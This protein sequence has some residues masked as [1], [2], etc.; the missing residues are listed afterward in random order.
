MKTSLRIIKYLAAILFIAQLT[1]CA[2][3]PN[4][5]LEGY[6]RQVF[7]FNEMLDAVVLKPVAHSYSEVVPY[8]AQTAV[9]NF[10]SN[11]NDVWVAF[12]NFLQGRGDE[13]FTDVSRV[14]INTFAGMGGL[15]DVASQAGL[16]KNTNDLGRTL[17]VW[18]APAGPYFVLPVLGPS[19]VRDT[20]AAPADYWFGDP[21]TYVNDR[22]FTWTAFVVRG[23]SWRAQ[24]LD[25]ASVI[26]DA[27]IDKYEF[28][29][30]AWL[31]RREHLV[32]SRIPA[33]EW[34]RVDLK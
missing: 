10:F 24:L 17:G 26:D 12:N 19:T 20:I 8:P 18:G 29:R 3:S 28:M 33:S 34:E 7:Y 31:Q 2:N 14:I 30:E 32:R 13:G 16:T 11:I 5:P 21:L 4:D 25:A 6:N 15:V 23:I 9:A 1:G 27:A 22:A